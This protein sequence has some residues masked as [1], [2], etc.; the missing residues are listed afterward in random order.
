MDSA[1]TSGWQP[2]HFKRRLKTPT[3]IA[4]R[5]LLPLAIAALPLVLLFSA[6]RTFHEVDLQRAIFLRHR[7]AML[8]G[9]LENVPPEASPEEV[10]E[11][12]SEDEPYLIGVE[13]IARGS[14]ADTPDLAALWDGE[15]LFRTIMVHSREAIIFRAYV[16]FHSANGLRLASIDLNAA[17]ADFLV[18]HARHNVIVASVGGLMLVVL[19]I[20][21]LWAMRRAA[22]SRE[23]EMAMEHLAHIGK[24]SAALAHEIRNPLGTIK[25]FVQL[26]AERADAGTQRLLTPVLGE[27]GRLESLVTDLLAYGRPPRPAPR[28]VKWSDVATGLAEHARQMIGE[29]PIH[30]KVSADELEWRTDPALLGQA[31]VNLVRNGVEAISG[32]GELR[33]EAAR[34]PKGD[35]VISITDTGTGISGDAARRLFEPFFTTKASGTG[36][37]LAI[38]RR[39]VTS[40]GGSLE[41]RA[42]PEGGT[43]AL[44]RMP[45]AD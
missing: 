24:M 43:E 19:S 31:L 39:V 20:Y 42:R 8:A 13:I 44:V 7:V 21:S 11:T 34:A 36:L 3:R 41:L 25:G 29:K 12:L 28:Q 32:D 27:T 40:L 2:N 37:G 38:T 26:A 14:A 5:I 45:A 35:I 17:A 15:E 18:V 6:I 23:R 9:R 1:V 10:F 4:S 16:P 22:K 33:I 30:L